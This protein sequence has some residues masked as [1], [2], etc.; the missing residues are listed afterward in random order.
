MSGSFKNINIHALLDVVKYI[1]LKSF[2]EYLLK[3]KTSNLAQL[4]AMRLN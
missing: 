4:E 1:Y 2:S 3:N